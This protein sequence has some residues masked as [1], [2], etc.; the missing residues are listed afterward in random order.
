[1]KNTGSRAGTETGAGTKTGTETETGDVSRQ[2]SPRELGQ[3]RAAQRAIL[4]APS[5]AAAEREYEHATRFED[6][7]EAEKRAVAKRQRPEPEPASEEDEEEEDDEVACPRTE[8]SKGE[9]CHARGRGRCRY[10]ARARA[11]EEKGGA[12]REHKRAAQPQQPA[13]GARGRDLGRT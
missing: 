6:L 9:A 12:H 2:L 5:G 3:Q 1:M 11:Q 13:V 4:E 10:R 7:T 8:G